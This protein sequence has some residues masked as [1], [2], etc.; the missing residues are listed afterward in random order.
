VIFG[1]LVLPICAIVKVI[2]AKFLDKLPNAVDEN[3]EIDPNDPIM[4]AYLKNAKGSVIKPK[5]AVIEEA[6]PSIQ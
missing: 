5:A 3:K 4:G 2:P 6:N 1:F